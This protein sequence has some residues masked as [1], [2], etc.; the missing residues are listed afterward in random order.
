MKVLIIIL[1]SLI[2]LMT[3]CSNSSYRAS[4]LWQERQMD[5]DLRIYG[6]P[7][8]NSNRSL[9]IQLPAIY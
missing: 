9:G 2:V 6:N 7:Y 1:L 5:D 8:E 4:S 3:G